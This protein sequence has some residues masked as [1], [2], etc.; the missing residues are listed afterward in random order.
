MPSLATRISYQNLTLATAQEALAEAAAAVA[1][2]TNDLE[3][4][5]G[6]ELELEA[7]TVGG[8]RFVNSGGVLIAEP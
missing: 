6:G 8:Q 3:A 2:A 4:L 1:E 7:I 5:A